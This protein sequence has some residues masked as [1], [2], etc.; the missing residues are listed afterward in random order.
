MR[1]GSQ[2]LPVRRVWP[3]SGI[4]ERLTNREMVATIRGTRPYD[5]Q[6]TSPRHLVSA[7]AL[8]VPLTPLV[9]RQAEVAAILDILRR[10]DTRLLT[11][12]GPG[13]AGKTRLALAVAGSVAYT[14]GV[15]FVDLSAI[16]DPSHVPGA[17][18]EALRV[19][20]SPTQALPER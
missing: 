15:S 4:F 13:G 10:P 1:T 16:V 18:A 7:T 12:T 5:D 9:G 19:R 6:P 11:L 3:R 14:D 20:E 17:I 8:P 2:W